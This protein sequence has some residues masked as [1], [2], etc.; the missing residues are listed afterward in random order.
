MAMGSDKMP[1][2]KEVLPHIFCAV[3]MSGMGVAL[4]PVVGQQVAK[5]ITK[6]LQLD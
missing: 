1:I 2:V 4:A 5:M 3:K 6:S